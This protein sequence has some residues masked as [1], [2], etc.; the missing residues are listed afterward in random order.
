MLDIN[1]YIYMNIS[2][3][4]FDMSK[5]IL[6]IDFKIIYDWFEMSIFFF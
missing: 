3:C 2:I 5:M 6:F 1:T 4:L